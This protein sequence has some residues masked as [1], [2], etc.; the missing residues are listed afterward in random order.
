[1]Q[2]CLDGAL[3]PIGEN[4]TVSADD[5]LIEILTKQQYDIMFNEEIH[6]ERM[7]IALHNAKHCAADMLRDCV[8]G[9]FVIPNKQQPID[10][11]VIF[12][13][14]MTQ[15]KLIFVDDTGTVEKMIEKLMKIQV[16]KKTLVAHFFF[17][18]LE[19]IIRDDS[20]YLQEYDDKLDTV[21]ENIVNG[22]K[23]EYEMEILQ[24]KKR[25]SIIYSY[26]QQLIDL[27]DNLWENYNS[28]FSKED[29]RLFNF[30]SKRVSRLCDSVNGLKEYAEQIK[31]M[32]EAKVNSRQNKIMQ[33][34]TVVTTIFMPL[35][36]ITGWYGMNFQ[37]MPELSW[38]NGYYVVIIICVLIVAIEFAVLKI[39]NWWK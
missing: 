20:T 5:V 11:N 3:R 23:A 12:G 14:Y 22:V 38:A 35:T 39:K 29:C 6:K 19:Y 10:N 34:L 25:L 37:N 21:E 27:S 1:M 9:T 36:L 28:M 13:F 24:I 26:Y 30:Y 17:E 18:F 8:V 31:S 16:M 15:G 2:Y 4:E 32:Y 33:V 7:N